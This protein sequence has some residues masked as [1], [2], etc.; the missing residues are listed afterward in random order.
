[1]NFSAYSSRDKWGVAMKIKQREPV[2]YKE[3]FPQGTR[4]RIENREWRVAHPLRHSITEGAPSFRGFCERVGT[5]NFDAR[6]IVVV[7]GLTS[8][9]TQ[10]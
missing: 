5:T 9:G 4:V 10:T 2:P 7:L 1:M 6:R 8:S 3:A